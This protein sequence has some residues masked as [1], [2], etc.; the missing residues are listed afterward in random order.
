MLKSSR[1]KTFLRAPF[2]GFIVWAMII[3]DRSMVFAYDKGLD[4]WSL[5]HILTGVGLG[6][7]IKHVNIEQLQ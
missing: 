1:Y 2:V 4:I 5:V 3:T 6:R 7:C